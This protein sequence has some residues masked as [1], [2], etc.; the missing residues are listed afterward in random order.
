MKDLWVVRSDVLKWTLGGK[1][2][3]GGETLIF[4]HEYLP[5]PPSHNSA[6]PVPLRTDARTHRKEISGPLGP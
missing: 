5:K 3:T 2:G 6:G 4:L 1:G